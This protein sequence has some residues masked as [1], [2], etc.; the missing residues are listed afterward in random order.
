ME[1]DEVVG[2][3]GAWNE[4][5]G[6]EGSGVEEVDQGEVCEGE[7]RGERGWRERGVGWVAGLEGVRA[8]AGREGERREGEEQQQRCRQY[9]HDGLRSGWDMSAVVGTVVLVES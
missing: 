7:E 1:T 5:F 3:W 6:K 9:E 2:A 8:W 4:E